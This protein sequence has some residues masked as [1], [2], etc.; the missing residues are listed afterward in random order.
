M[1]L[2]TTVVGYCRP[3]HLFVPLS[4]WPLYC[5]WQL[6]READDDGD[7]DGDNDD[8]DD[9][10]DDKD[11]DSD[12]DGDEEAAAVKMMVMTAGMTMMWGRLF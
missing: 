7:E 11:D 2:C 5:G 4:L 12:D 6:H 10:D 3:R 9:G 1:Y 8:D